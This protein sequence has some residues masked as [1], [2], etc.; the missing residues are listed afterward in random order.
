MHEGMK[1]G[2]G[3]DGKH[4]SKHEGMEGGGGMHV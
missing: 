3:N 1:M 2:K 4:A